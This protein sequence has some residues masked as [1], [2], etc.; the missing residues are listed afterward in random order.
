MERT[1]GNKYCMTYNFSVFKVSIIKKKDHSI[2][3]I[4]YYLQ[5][6]AY[7]KGLEISLTD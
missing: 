4:W 1:K 3:R 5:F 7:T 6:Q 2:Y